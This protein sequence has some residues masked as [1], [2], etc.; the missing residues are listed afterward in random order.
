MGQTTPPKVS[1]EEV[2]IKGRRVVVRE[3]VPKDSYVIEYEAEVYPR[4]ERAAREREYVWNGEG[5]FIV[6]VQ[7]SDGWMCLDGTRRLNSLGRLLNHAPRALATLAPFGPLFL[8]GKW[9]VG[10]IATRNLCVGEELTW[11]YGCAPN[12]IDWLRRRPKQPTC[13]K[14]QNVFA[15]V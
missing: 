8:N 2:P 13:G 10:F 7:T 9:R 11:D 12:G 3:E 15:T 14:L 4:R 5:C 1:I 6:D